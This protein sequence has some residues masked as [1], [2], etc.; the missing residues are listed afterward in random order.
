MICTFYS[1]KG[2]VG[3]SM[4]LANVGDVLSRRGLKV[5]MIDFDLEAPGLEQF[6]YRGDERE[7]R[8][9]IRGQTGLLDLLL[10]YKESMSVA[11]GGASFREIE[12]FIATIFAQR[13]GGGRL[14]LMPAGQRLSAEQLSHYAQAL[15]QFDWQDFYFNWEGDLFFEW[16]RRTLVPERYDVVLIDSRTGVTEM[17]GICG[18][19]LADVIVMMCGANHQNV[20]GTW[21]MLHDFRSQP[22]AD[23]R[24]GRPLE[25]VVVPARVEQRT[26]Q[27]T[28]AFQER[29]DARFA[30]LLPARMAELGLSFR[31]LTIPYDPQFAFEERVARSAEEKAAK[32]HLAQVFGTLAD[33]ITLLAPIEPDAPGRLAEQSRQVR[34]RLDGLT[35][36]APGG[37]TGRPASAVAATAFAKYDETKRFADFDA[38]LAF[39]RPDAEAAGALQAALTRTG[40]RVL[41]DLGAPAV[42]AD[43]RQRIQESLVHA[44]AVAFCVGSGALDASHRWL[45]ERVL[46]ARAS[47]RDLKAVA[48]LLPGHRD[49]APADTTLQGLPM[50]DLRDGPTGAALV[51]AME[52]LRPAG[53]TTDVGSDEAP[54]V[55]REERCPWVGLQPF[56]EHQA[57]LFFGR[58]D[59]VRRLA[60]ALER[61]PVVLV[62][63]ASACGK[64]SLLRAGLVPALRRAKPDW[65]VALAHDVEAL[66]AATASS[67]AGAS[68][69]A[70]LLV[71]DPAPE[72]PAGAAAAQLAT[73]LEALVSAGARLVIAVRSGQCRA[74]SDLWTARGRGEPTRIALERPDAA[75]LRDLV[76]RP[77]DAAGL[78]FE[79]G[80]VDRLLN[81]ATGEPGVLPF[82]QVTL[83]RLWRQRRNGWLTNSAYDAFGGLRA[84]VTEAADSHF[85]ALGPEAQQAMR[86]ILLR[87][88]QFAPGSTRTSAQRVPRSSLGAQAGE[89][90][91]VLEGLIDARLLV[92]DLVDGESTIEPAHEALA[93]DWP[94]LLVWLEQ[95]RDF[96]AW[97]TRLTAELEA[98][99]RAGRS[100][101]QLLRGPLLEEAERF[102]SGREADLRD[103]ERAFVASSQSHRELLAHEAE[104]QRARRVKVLSAAAGVFMTV[105]TIAAAGWVQA[106]RQQGE[107]ERKSAELERKSEALQAQLDAVDAATHESEAE[108]A[109]AQRRL[110][111]LE[112]TLSDLLATARRTADERDAARAQLMDL[113]RAVQQARDV[114]VQQEAYSVRQIEQNT[115]QQAILRDALKSPPPVEAKK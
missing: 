7:L 92:S 67:R 78:A 101:E 73:R 38:L 37:K 61:A 96:L 71:L 113:E 33:V 80:L 109:A 79:P 28:E 52:A 5:L 44:R 53:T 68:E 60:E 46:Q 75:A 97:R 72:A 1:Y 66:T 62:C 36:A 11:G 30:A 50:L 51:R 89:A 22:V 55:E 83:E 23:L 4:A 41:A 74:W 42:G 94:R 8:D 107:L 2:G 105:A 54:E 112:A 110:T 58:G 48:V 16:L 106:I 29:F 103:E 104:R 14:D 35:P 39:A 59:D 99:T 70:R 63:G 90:K 64:T 88:V 24:R 31:D 98:W 47:G 12:R 102:S 114:A 91:A 49:D 25:I 9:A 40:L 13:P 87:L 65:R 21:S 26:P 95:E 108:R 77:A 115:R 43:W 17:G 100:D 20:D 82:L 34:S 45:L 93:R 85:E 86:R 57:D 6:F 56:E 32:E 111:E 84:V 15:R 27:L 69:G 3:R 18:Y 81:R 10:A 19:Q 76:E